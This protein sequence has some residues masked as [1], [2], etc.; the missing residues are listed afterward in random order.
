MPAMAT[1]T[2]YV[3]TMG[4]RLSRIS[5]SVSLKRRIRSSIMKFYAPSSDNRLL[6]VVKFAFVQLIASA[7]VA[8]AKSAVISVVNMAGVLALYWS[9]ASAAASSTI[10]AIRKMTKTTLARRP[11]ADAATRP[12]GA[13]LPNR[14]FDHHFPAGAMHKGM[15]RLKAG[16]VQWI[17]GGG[18]HAD[19]G[20]AAVVQ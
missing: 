10:P 3:F 9:P 20:L 4:K 19:G 2:M 14:C 15:F 18:D 12:S 1:P 17:V 8:V 6:V 7:T 11:T 13:V 16:T 5:M